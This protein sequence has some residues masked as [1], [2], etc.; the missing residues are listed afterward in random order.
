M[1]R[2]TPKL[3][4]LAEQLLGY[5]AESGKAAA[6]NETAAFRVSEKVRRLL[7]SLLG[8]AGF[9]ALL[10]RALTLARAE[11]PELSAVTVKPD[12]SLEGLNEL[13]P[14]SAAGESVRGEILLIAKLLELLV[15]FI[16]EALMLSLVE[17]AWPEA[18]FEDPTREKRKNP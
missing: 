7:I 16:G 12:G 15:I 11:A 9:R 5:E 17:D 8:V 2:T 1:K 3:N 4:G 14:R 13:A 10:L 18:T 6:A